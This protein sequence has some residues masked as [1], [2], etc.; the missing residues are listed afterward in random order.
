MVIGLLQRGFLAATLA[1]GV[2]GCG[3]LTPMPAAAS[4]TLLNVSYDPTRE[5]YVEFNKAFAE[6]WKTQGGETCGSTSRMAA[7]ASRRAR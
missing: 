5:L 6:Y 4:T 1:T 7:R 3:L 2:L